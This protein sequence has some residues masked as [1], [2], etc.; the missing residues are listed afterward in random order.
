[1]QEI[2]LSIIALR[3]VDTSQ[4]PRGAPCFAELDR[5][6]VIVKSEILTSTHLIA[7]G[8]KNPPAS[9]N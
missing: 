1:M 7:P 2:N 9:P 6:T 4:P 8:D 3:A 5:N